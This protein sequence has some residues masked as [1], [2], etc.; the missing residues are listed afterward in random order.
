MRRAL[1][2]IML[3]TAAVGAQELTDRIVA[4]VEEEPIFLSDLDN[5]VA[6]DL[7][8]KQLRGETVPTEPAEL[9][10]L[11]RDLLESIIERRIV[12]VKAREAGIEVTGTEVED[13]LDQWLPGVIQA[14][15]SEEVFLQELA[16]QG[17]TLQEFKAQYRKAIEE[18]LLVSRFVRQEFGAVSVSEEEVQRFFDVKY[19]SIPEIPDIVG[20]SHIIIIPGA[21]AEREAAVR[22]KLD[23]IVQRLGGGEP[24]ADVAR[25]VSDDRLTRERG[26]RIGIVR[27]GDLRP[28]LARIV[29][30][31]EPGR[32]SEPVRTAYGF[33]IVKID[34]QIGEQFEI[35]HIS[36]RLQ[37]ERE[38]TLRAARLA[39]DVRDRAEAGESFE[40]LAR[41]YSDD[42]ETRENGGYIGEVEISTLDENYRSGLAGLSPGEVSEVIE[43]PF[44]F[45][46]LKLVSRTASRKPRFDEAR[47]WIRNLIQARRRE[48]LFEGWL[49]NARQEV[50]VERRDL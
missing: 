2:L 19:D 21:S 9:D 10:S 23:S 22:D 49:E 46:I 26:G 30:G 6:E 47:E 40:G 12:I 35:S 1:V 11:R 28:E 32:V 42:P 16:R 18:E 44:G 36:L 20:V 39:Q 25:D 34:S 3:L 41:Q 45:Q 43:T 31:L 5:A 4:V 24:F 48:R 29:T 7:Y 13:A 27:L 37:S 14:A 38:D 50:Y 17:T 8:L 15:G 33:E